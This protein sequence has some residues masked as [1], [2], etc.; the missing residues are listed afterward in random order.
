MINNKL[1]VTMTDKFM[2]NWGMAD[3]KINKLVI[4]CDTMEEAEIV[5]E[6]AKNRSEMN[7]VNICMNKPHY[8]SNRYLTSFETKEGYGRWFTKG[9]FKKEK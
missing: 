1:Y 4:E 8:D 7:R 3:N 6:N 5:E 9:G 2:S